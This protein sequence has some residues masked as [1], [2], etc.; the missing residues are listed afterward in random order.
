MEGLSRLVSESLARNGVET[1]LVHRRLQW[2]RWLRCERSFSTLLIPSKPGL[3]A[4]G[5]EV[6]AP[7]E[8]PV[9]RGKRMLALF[10]IS[11]TEELGMTLGGLFLPGV[12]DRERVASIR[13][14]VLYARL[15]HARY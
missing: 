2:S 12:L 15:D 9:T 14:Y 6:I 1:P 7:G 8:L 5:Q 11:E 10:R 4:F 13:F 3:Y